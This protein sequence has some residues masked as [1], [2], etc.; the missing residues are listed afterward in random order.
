MLHNGRIDLLNL[1]AL[2]VLQAVG[3]SI[4]LVA[5][6]MRNPLGLILEHKGGKNTKKEN[7]LRTYLEQPHGPDAVAHIESEAMVNT[8]R[9]D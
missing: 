2:Q 9:E 8:R 4:R 1:N 6:V 3:V 5:T 7:R